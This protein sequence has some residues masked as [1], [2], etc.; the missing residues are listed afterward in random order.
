MTDRLKSSLQTL[1]EPVRLR[2]VYN[3]AV[4]CDE[5]YRDQIHRF[6]SDQFES[7]PSISAVDL[8]AGIA[9]EEVGVWQI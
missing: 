4:L 7:L 8:P 9:L 6:L 2:G 5:G 3:L 1:I